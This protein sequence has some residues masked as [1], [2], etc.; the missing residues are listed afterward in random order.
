MNDKTKGVVK[1][2]LCLVLYNNTHI[3]QC[4]MYFSVSYSCNFKL[5]QNI[6]NLSINIDAVSFKTKSCRR[7]ISVSD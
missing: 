1:T 2:V 4:L 3:I 5:V 7:A 6:S